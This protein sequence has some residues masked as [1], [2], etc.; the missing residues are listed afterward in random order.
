LT[1]TWFDTLKKD[2]PKDISVCKVNTIIFSTPTLAKMI[3]KIL[4]WIPICPIWEQIDDVEVY[5][6]QIKGNNAIYI[7]WSYPSQ[8]D[9]ELKQTQNYAPSP[10]SIMDH[11]PFSPKSESVGGDHTK[12]IISDMHML[13]LNQGIQPHIFATFI[14][15]SLL[16]VSTISCHKH[17]LC[18]EREYL[19]SQ[20]QS[21]YSFPGT[22]R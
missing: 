21:S 10:N 15:Q 22:S 16:L 6:D 18:T 14:P 7:P 12:H 9:P 19:F 3:L 11:D 1:N 2:Q 13:L 5:V 4:N 8:L 20:P 17:D